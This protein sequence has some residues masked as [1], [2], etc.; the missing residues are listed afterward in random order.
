ML[1]GL[2]SAQGLPR[3]HSSSPHTLSFTEPD[4][5]MSASRWSSRVIGMVSEWVRLDGVRSDEAAHH[6][7]AALPAHAARLASEAAFRREVAW[8]VH[9]S[10]PAIIVPNVTPDRCDNAA[11]CI[12]QAL[13]QS[14]V[15]QRQLARAPLHGV[16]A[17][18]S[19]T[20]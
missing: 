20:V 10:L 2:A 13:L 14:Q 11:R 5:L 9:L 3:T 12:N 16:R 15:R 18:R 17:S 19:L 1:L 6:P 4:T 7:D 8:A